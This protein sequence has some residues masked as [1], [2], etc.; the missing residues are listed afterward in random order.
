MFRLNKRW[1]VTLFLCLLI[2]LDEFCVKTDQISSDASREVAHWN[3]EQS[4]VNFV[5][6]PENDVGKYILI[7]VKITNDIKFDR[8]FNCYGQIEKCCMC[9]SY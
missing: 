6:N 5:D 2:L 9:A 8:L 4:P 1:R 3:F 7:L